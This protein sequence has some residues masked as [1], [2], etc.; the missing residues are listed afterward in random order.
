MM[1]EICIDDLVKQ[2]ES[3]LNEKQQKKLTNL[4]KRVEWLQKYSSENGVTLVHRIPVQPTVEYVT[5]ETERKK[6]WQCGNSRSIDCGSE[7]VEHKVKQV[8]VTDENIIEAIKAIYPEHV[9][10][11]LYWFDNGKYLFTTD[12]GV[13]YNL[14][15]T[16]RPFTKEE[17]QTIRNIIK[18]IEEQKQ[19]VEQQLRKAKVLQA[20][21]TPADKRSQEQQ[22]LANSGE[23]LMYML[24]LQKDITRASSSGV[25]KHGANGSLNLYG[26]T[27][28]QSVLTSV[29]NQTSKAKEEHLK[30]VENSLEKINKI[31]S[32][33]EDEP[34]YYVHPM[35]DN[36][37]LKIYTSKNVAKKYEILGYTVYYTE[38]EQKSSRYA[39]N[40]GEIIEEEIEF[41][42]CSYHFQMNRKA[43][44]SCCF[45]GKVCR[46][47]NYY[48]NEGNEVEITR[49][50]TEAITIKD[51]TGN[52]LTFNSKSEAAKHFNVSNSEISK[53]IKNCSQGDIPTI[54][55]TNTKNNQKCIK[56]MTTDYNVLQF[57]S[58]TEAAK[59]LNTKNYTLSRLL[60][61]KV[62]GDTVTIN[63][64]TYTL[65]G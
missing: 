27:A 56:L 65:V 25:F 12:K 57:S 19:Q 26:E 40:K 23:C 21:R 1:N 7:V 32:Q 49:R 47:G 24:E 31:C 11:K 64:S 30:D 41:T 54:N 51:E 39:S 50:P 60:K 3:S 48:D 29:F 63:G 2:V 9:E 59:E 22:E 43:F 55:T 45:N 34:L 15:R 16:P 5:F 53:L 62:K 36:K 10:S 17:Q 33:C 4:Q 6:T 8:V 61:G 20:Y 38:Q 46:K 28:E 58:M 14:R 18:D 44:I 13:V 35:K 52:V 42:K 37:Q